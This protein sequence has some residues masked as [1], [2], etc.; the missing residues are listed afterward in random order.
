[1]DSILK[2]WK[3]TVVALVVGIFSC[4]ALIMWMQGKIDDTKLAMGLAS[5]AALGT[6]LGN[7]LGKDATDS[8]TKRS[9]IVPPPGTPDKGKDA[10]K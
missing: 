9:S 8:H 2:S 4:I 6:T 10:N 7:L 1:M 5:I 3:T